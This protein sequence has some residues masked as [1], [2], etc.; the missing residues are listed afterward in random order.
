MSVP[1][2]LAAPA[3]LLLLVSACG[4]PATPPPAAD[5]TDSPPIAA[6]VREAWQTARDTLLD[7]DSPAIWHGPQG[8]AWLLV[9]A[10]AGD[11][12]RVHDAATGKWLRDV[13]TAGR[14]PGQFERPN[15]LAVMDDLLWV[16]ERDGRRVQ[17]L[18]LPDFTPLGSYGEGDLVKP[19]GISVAVDGAGNYR[20]W[21]TDSYELVK[22]SVPPD[23][24]LGRRV[25]E[26]RVVVRGGRATAALVRTF[27]D[28]TGAGVLRVVE[29]IMA[30]P[31][32]DQL[33]IAE[34]LEG[35]SQLKRYT[36]AGRFTGDTV[37]QR[38]FPNQAEGIVLYACG[39]SAGYWVATDQGK[40]INT[41]HLFDRKTLAHVGAFGSPTIKNTD[42]IALTQRAL[43]GFRAGALF[44]VHDDGG[45]AAISWEAI[46][47]ATGVRSDCTLK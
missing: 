28:T 10:K 45:V 11:L 44:A 47:K 23:S 30:D 14:G 26:Y 20:T 1:S 32:N 16:V 29:S 46:A 4:R 43:P 37:P 27:G 36:L 9:S 35:A 41:Y 13:G 15:G 39:D 25:R 33:L 38:F 5:M 7:I 24:A 19:Y 17:L 2:S 18:Q 21:I 12:I 31:A 3:V 6:E 22:D 40:V 8:E 34:E 42:G